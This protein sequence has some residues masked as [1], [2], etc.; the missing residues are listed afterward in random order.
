ARREAPRLRRAGAPRAPQRR[1][2]RLQT[3][4]EKTRGQR[5][6]DGHHAV[7]VPAA[8]AQALS[9][10][11]LPGLRLVQPRGV[12]DAHL[13]QLAQPVH[14]VTQEREPVTQIGAET[15]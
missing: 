2:D 11:A 7:E 14:G 6:L 12:D 15:E 9:R 1:L 13:G 4:E 5:G 8:L 3:L 10:L